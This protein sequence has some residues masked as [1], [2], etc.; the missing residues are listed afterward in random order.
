[1][2]DLFCLQCEYRSPSYVTQCLHDCTQLDSAAPC[3]TLIYCSPEQP[4][5]ASLVHCLRLEYP[6]ILSI[7]STPPSSLKFYFDIISSSKPSLTS[8][9]GIPLS[10]LPWFFDYS[11][12]W[13]RMYCATEIIFF[14]ALLSHV[15]W[16][17]RERCVC[18]C[19]PG[20]PA[21]RLALTENWLNA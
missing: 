6:G 17:H 21:Q 13:I 14:Q 19:I 11:P 1:M 10:V 8:P 4:S 15:L 3:L 16:T 18:I 12:F 2:S 7:M 9:G 20:I 5:S